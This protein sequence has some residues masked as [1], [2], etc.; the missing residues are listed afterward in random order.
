MIHDGSV[1]TQL[2]VLL[3]D[4][5]FPIADN[6]TRTGGAAGVLRAIDADFPFGCDE[7][8]GRYGP[9]SASIRAFMCAS[10]RTATVR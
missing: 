8:S 2:N 10:M 7:K 6:L 9:S 1:R 5:S 3:E 4:L